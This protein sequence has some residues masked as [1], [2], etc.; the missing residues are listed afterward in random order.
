MILALLIGCGVEERFTLVGDLT[1]DEH[2]FTGQVDASTAFAHAQDGSLVAYISSSPDTTC[3]DVVSYVSDPIFDL[4][5]M[6]VS[7]HCN[8]FIRIEGDYDSSGF[9]VED[10]MLYGASTIMGCALGEG[11]FTQ[12]DANSTYVWSGQWWQ[13]APTDFRYDFSDDGV[14]YALNMSLSTF[15]GSFSQDGQMIS[16]SATAAIEGLATAESCPELADT[17]LFD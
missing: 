17:Y 14:D 15:N 7:N 6:F 16:V 2:D 13:G 5:S 9:S 8:L 11:E 12:A 1:L 10:D 3:A 4:G